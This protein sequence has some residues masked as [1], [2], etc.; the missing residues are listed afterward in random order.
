M[1]YVTNAFVLAFGLLQI[2]HTFLV[3]TNSQHNVGRNES[4]ADLVQRIDQLQVQ[5]QMQNKTIENQG[6]IIEQLLNSTRQSQ[7][8]Q[9]L[10]SE[11]SVLQSYVQRIMDEYQR[12]SQIAN[13]TE[14]ASKIN[15][16]AHSIRNLATSLTDQEHVDLDIKKMFD[17]LNVTMSLISTKVTGLTNDLHSTRRDLQSLQSLQVETKQYTYSHIS[18]LSSQYSLLSSR[19]HK[20]ED[21]VSTLE[22]NLEMEVITGKFVFIFIVVLLLS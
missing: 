19:E 14:L 11:L 1:A 10:S 12:L 13:T 17:S 5:L 20:T 4:Q 22:H 16:M 18:S 21:R 9:S 8:I 3:D 2:A 7:S 15:N 6:A